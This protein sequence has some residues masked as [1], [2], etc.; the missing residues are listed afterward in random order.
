MRDITE[1]SRQFGVNAEWGTAGQFPY[2]LQHMCEKS[3]LVIADLN[4]RPLAEPLLRR[5]KEAGCKI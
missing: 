2:F 5:L 4:T 3:V 1:L